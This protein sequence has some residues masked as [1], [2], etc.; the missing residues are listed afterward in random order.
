[1][2]APRHRS[3]RFHSELFDPSVST[4]NSSNLGPII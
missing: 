4:Q 1:L 3:F 2:G